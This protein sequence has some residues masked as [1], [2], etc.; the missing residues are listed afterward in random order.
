M[1][2]SKLPISRVRFEKL[3]LFEVGGGR[4]LLADTK[5]ITGHCHS[6]ENTAGDNPAECGKRAKD[7]DVILGK[8][9]PELLHNLLLDLGLEVEPSNALCCL[10]C[11]DLRSLFYRL[12][13]R[14]A[15]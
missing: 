14:L 12:L 4:M 2:H 7:G 1:P 5:G 11:V 8:L 13:C 6:K 15:R 3:L 10:C 9:H